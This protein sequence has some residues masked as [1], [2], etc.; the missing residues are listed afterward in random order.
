[1]V[2]SGSLLA[3]A[4]RRLGVLKFSPEIAAVVDGGQGLEEGELSSGFSTSPS[5]TP[6]SK[7]DMVVCGFLNG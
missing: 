1:M 4:L 3:A 5:C 7:V 2:I 6:P